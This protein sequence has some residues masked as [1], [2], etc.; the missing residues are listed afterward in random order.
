MQT[1]EQ[2]S[3]LHIKALNDLLHVVTPV[4]QH[5]IRCPSGEEA[6]LATGPRVGDGNEEENQTMQ[7]TEAP[8]MRSVRMHIDE[9]VVCEGM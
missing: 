4:L 2:T 8:S 9:Q 3:S 6:Q 5:S 1:D 7:W